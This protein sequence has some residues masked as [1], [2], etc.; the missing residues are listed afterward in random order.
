VLQHI[1]K[2][3]VAAH[4]KVARRG[5]GQRE[6]LRLARHRPD[7][8]Q[9]DRRALGERELAILAQRRH[10]ARRAQLAHADIARQRLAHRGRRDRL[11]GN[12]PGQRLGKARQFEHACDRLRGRGIEEAGIAKGDRGGVTGGERP[13]EGEEEAGEGVFSRIVSLWP[14]TANSVPSDR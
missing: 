1:D 5:L 4:G 14:W 11:V 12:Q 2:A 3:I 8:D 13:V 7:I 6:H 10:P 9:V